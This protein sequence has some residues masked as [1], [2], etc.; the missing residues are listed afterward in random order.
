[1]AQTQRRQILI[2]DD[3]PGVI[4]VL[5]K[6]LAPAGF[7]IR[8]ATRGT[9]GVTAAMQQRP[10]LVILDL[11]LPDMSGYEVCRELRKLYHRWEVP[12]LMLTCLDRPSDQLRGFAHGAEAYLTKP[13]DPVELLQTIQLLLGETVPT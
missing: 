5:K 4:E 9:A 13:Y 3:E 1:M 11:K 8:A 6:R 10:D 2:I 12:I 7:E